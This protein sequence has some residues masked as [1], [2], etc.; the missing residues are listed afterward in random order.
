MFF[1]L[2]DTF[3]EV[4][5]VCAVVKEESSETLLQFKRVEE[6]PILI[7]LHIDIKLLVPQ[8]TSVAIDIHQLEKY[9]VADEVVNQHNRTTQ[10]CVRPL[11]RVR[12][13]NVEP[14]NGC[15]KHLL[16][17]L[18]NHTLHLLLLSGAEPHFQWRAGLWGGWIKQTFASPAGGVAIFSGRKTRSR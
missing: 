10:P 2:G 4:C 8:H 12:V 5:S 9:R 17:R 1:S 6:G 16:R 14:G 7:V 18:G 15:I 11:L 3:E 13:R